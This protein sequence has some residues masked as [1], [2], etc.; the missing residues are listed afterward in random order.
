MYRGLI[1]WTFLSYSH[2]H[3]HTQ[4]HTHTSLGGDLSFHLEK[5]GR[6]LVPRVKLYLAELALALEYLKE[7][8]IIHRDVK[9][10]NVLLDSEGHAHLTDFNVACLVR[11]GVS[12]TSVTG[13]KPYMG[14]TSSLYLSPL[15]GMENFIR[16]NPPI[17][18]IW[19]NLNH[20]SFLGTF[21]RKYLVELKSLFFHGNLP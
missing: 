18:S 7:K 15:K 17:E 19:W 2:T 4:T 8:N 10:A 20:C 6:F 5:E 11:P 3:T 16:E 12:V 1:Q 9:P 13:T 21:P 14:K